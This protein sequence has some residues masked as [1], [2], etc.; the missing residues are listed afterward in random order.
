MTDTTLSLSNTTLGN[1][2]AIR[3]AADFDKNSSVT[4]L[5]LDHCQIGDTGANALAR[6]LDGNQS[7][8]VLHLEYND[9]GDEGAKAIS[10]TFRTSASLMTVYLMNNYIGSDGAHAIQNA[11]TT[12][13][14]SN[15]SANIFCH[16]QRISRRILVMNVDTTLHILSHS[17]YI[18]LLENFIF[19]IR[20][21]DGLIVK[22]AKIYDSEACAPELT[23]DEQLTAYDELQ[24]GQNMKINDAYTVFRPKSNVAEERI[25]DRVSSFSEFPSD[26][27][28]TADD[29]KSQDTSV[30]YRD[31][32]VWTVLLDEISSNKSVSEF[33]EKQNREWP[34]FEEMALRKYDKAIIDKLLTLMDNNAMAGNI[35]SVLCGVVHHI[36]DTASYSDYWGQPQLRRWSPL[37]SVADILNDNGDTNVAIFPMNPTEKPNP[38]HQSIQPTPS[39]QYKGV[40]HRPCIALQVKIDRPSVREYYSIWF[41][42]DTGSPETSI[43]SDAMDH[44]ITIYHQ[45][46]GVLARAREFMADSES[47][48]LRSDQRTR[49]GVNIRSHSN[50]VEWGPI[51]CR[52]SDNSTNDVA[53]D[54][55]LLGTDF[56]WRLVASFAYPQHIQFLVN[57]GREEAVATAERQTKLENDAKSNRRHQ[58]LQSIR[59]RSQ[60]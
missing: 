56:M 8:A 54:I 21:N 1:E 6:A 58:I 52:R 60:H 7:V 16:N 5:Y 34:L 33:D 28:A 25:P 23:E 39:W 31:R 35:I 3:L 47:I 57:P 15:R 14:L 26:A 49:F 2:G 45:S 27:T 55:N 17:T 53:H 51:Y 19:I 24:P 32:L 4:S 18:P 11:L 10:E 38:L 42:T 50:D 22:V 43:T 40:H 59:E 48:P 12:R 9:I 37:T 44:I 41:L 20:S 29:S 13:Q 30:F 36:C 46:R